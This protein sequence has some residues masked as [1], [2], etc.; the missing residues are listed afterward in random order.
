[1]VLLAYSTVYGQQ[2]FAEPNFDFLRGMGEALG[3]RVAPWFGTFFWSIG[4]V[5]LFA[6][7]LG[8]LDYVGRIVS[9]IL[10]VS[11]LA[12]SERWTESRIYFAVVWGEILT[13]TAILLAGLDAPLVLLLIAQSIN[14]MIMFVY[15]ALLIKLNRSVLPSPAKPGGVRTSIMVGAVLFY[16][17]F[18]G[19]LI[20]SQIKSLLGG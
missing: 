1:M 18:A 13:G 8:I 10:K 7:A 17:F 16:G 19:F 6:A 2:R 5:S 3:Q 14:G 4:A 15:C 12:D 9:D 20:F 11:Y